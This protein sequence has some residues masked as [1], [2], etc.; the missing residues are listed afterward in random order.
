MKRALL[1][2]DI[3][4]TLLLTDG[5]GMRGMARASHK[6]YGESFRW[7]GVKASGRLDPVI[8][9]DALSR[10]G[11]TMS[12]DA[13]RRFHDAYLAELEVELERVGAG[14]RTMPGIREILATLVERSA[15]R[16]DVVQGL[17]TGNYTRAA[18]LKLRACGLDPEWFVVNA[19]GDEGKTRPDLVALAMKRC[20]DRFG[21]S[22][23]PRSVI[24]IGDTPFDVECA[25]AHGCVAFAVATGLHGVEEL[26]AS[27]AD[28]VVGDLSDP[29]PLFALVDG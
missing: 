1:L 26:R 6:I 2:W 22:P 29:A 28:V 21:W 5:A 3:D 14:A 20:A 16:K 13:H 12:E 24:V 17:L 11:L 10:N 8:F 18:P 19:F 25:R 9:E 15:S 27:G 23:D 7:D 4:G